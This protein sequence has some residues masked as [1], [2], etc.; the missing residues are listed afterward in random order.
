MPGPSVPA[1]TLLIAA[2]LLL[3]TLTAAGGCRTDASSDDP[4][5]TV[6]NVEFAAEVA[7]T[8]AERAQGLSGRPSLRPGVGMLFVFDSGRASTFWMKGMLFPLDIVWID[9]DW[10]VI[11]VT[12]EAAVPS[13][14]TSDQELPRYSA[15]AVPVRY[16]LEINAGVARELGIGPGQQAR[17]LGLASPGGD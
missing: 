14:D 13:P 12:H 10:R 15:G 4:T 1:R 11:Q 2:A 5:V 9:A 3:A 16:V 6:R 17:I 8:L 7:R